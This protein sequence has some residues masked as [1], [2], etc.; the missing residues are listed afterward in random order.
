M[1]NKTEE[2]INTEDVIDAKK[3]GNIEKPIEHANKVT[4][5]KMFAMATGSA[6]VLV[7]LITGV[8]TV[9]HHRNQ[10][11][12]TH[13]R[14]QQGESL[15]TNTGPQGTHV[16]APSGTPDPGQH[17][18]ASDNNSDRYYRTD[19][20]LIINS[21]DPLK[22]SV[23]VEYKGEY[24][25]LDGGATW[26]KLLT[27]YPWKYTCFPEPFSAHQ[28]PS[29]PKT[30]YLSASGDGL[31]KT[32]DGGAT[33][34]NTY[35]STMYPRSEEFVIDPTNTNIIYATAENIVGSDNPNDN[36]NLKNGLVYKSTDAGTTW[37]ELTTP[38]AAGASATNIVISKTDPKHIIAFTLLAHITQTVGR[39]VDTSGQLGILESKDAGLTWQSIHS[40]P[41]AYEAVVNAFSSQTNPNNIYI[42]SFTSSGV[43]QKGFF[44]TDFGKSW[45]ASNAMEF[46]AY[47]PYDATGN[48]ALAFGVANGATPQLYETTNAGMTWKASVKM[49]AEITDAG[50]RK[51]LLSSIQWDPK[52]KNTLYLSGAGATVWKSTDNGI[53]WKA[54]LSLVTLPN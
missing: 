9:V 45:A 16:P 4:S 2:I 46:V 8:I 19:R 13:D 27:S 5:G 30:F 28:S 38:L 26:K 44:T 34:K 17:S 35:S 20:S 21:S 51:T 25:S 33:W 10:D 18:C 36:S 47:D 1:D 14:P 15:A 23:G 11:T 54:L 22:L 32:T 42:A 49:P 24:Q 43:Q 31:L 50:D 3:S 53:T 40:V 52:D 6:V 12:S 41:T 7:L 48:H 29:D 37:T 39:Q